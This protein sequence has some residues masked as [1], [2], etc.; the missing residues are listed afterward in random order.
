[1]FCICGDVEGFEKKQ[2]RFS[3]LRFFKLIQTLVLHVPMYLDL[4]G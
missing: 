3:R 1:M 2:C 4:V